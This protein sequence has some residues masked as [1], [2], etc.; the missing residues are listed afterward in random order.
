[1]GVL[2]TLLEQRDAAFTE[3]SAFVEPIIAEKRELTGAEEVRKAELFEVVLKL[4]ERITE[5]D[6]QE[7]RDLRVADARK[8]VAA[9]AVI[10]S[11]QRTYGPGSDESYF[12]DFARAA[13]PGRADYQ[14]AVQRLSQHGK[15]VVRDAQNDP[16]E[17]A[18][19]V[20]KSK[21]YYRS[22]GL[23]SRQVVADLESRRGEMRAG[24]DTTAA[25]GGS[26]AT[27]QY[28]V[29]DWAPYR[30]F[31]R[32]YIDLTNLKPL[33]DYGMTVYLPQVTLASAVAAQVGQNQGIAET[34]PTAGYLSAN[35]T[36]EAGQV[37]ISQQLLDRAGPGIKFD[38]V[39]FDS[40]QRNY[41]QVIDTAVLT[42]AIANAG[43]VSNSQTGTSG[44]N[45]FQSFLSDI[46]NATQA[47]ETLQGT[48]MS[49]THAHVTGTE[50]AF[51]T[52]QLDST[53]RILVVPSNH[54]PFNANL[55]GGDNELTGLPEGDTGYDVGGVKIIKDSNIPVSGA[56]TRLVVS[57]MPEVWVW[58]GELVPRTIPQTFA[59]N[60]SILLQV[61]T[62]YTV[63]V[64]YAKAVQVISGNR[65]PASPTFLQA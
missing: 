11:E 2:A 1:M 21:E 38:K 51:L 29:E 54:G 37:T 9:P 32:N 36:T 12:L 55:V 7:R 45:V 34:D 14:D 52:A 60:L 25:S 18:R 49:P 31:G 46:G 44:T 8:R 56:N 17:R 47:M 58:E 42:A 39:V 28:L 27:P 5:V 23:R 41:A 35:L 63:I 48:V 62:Y 26:F 22:D 59:Q 65:Y 30:Q 64:R 61:Y 10:Q 19:L 6:E 33:P 57:H 13:W 53:G 15:E 24:M 40:L 4:D 3:A 16:D 20:R 43:T 50:W